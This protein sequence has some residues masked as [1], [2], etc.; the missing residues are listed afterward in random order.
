M[1]QQRS[2]SPLASAADERSS[3]LGDPDALPLRFTLAALV[4]RRAIF[5]SSQR[6]NTV[7]IAVNSW[8]SVIRRLAAEIAG[9]EREQRELKRTMAYL[10][11]GEEITRTGSWAWNPASGEL[12]WSLSG[13]AARASALSGD[14]AGTSWTSC[15]QATYLASGSSLAVS[16]VSRPSPQTP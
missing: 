10:A 6:F 5:A 3:E 2:R 12:F 8:T 15:F 4:A 14:G 1:S 13:G 11:L 16:S 7:L 9:H